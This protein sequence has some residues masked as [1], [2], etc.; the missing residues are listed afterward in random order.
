MGLGEKHDC[1]GL[2]GNGEPV[3]VVRSHFSRAGSRERGVLV[4]TRLSPLQCVPTP[5]LWDDATHF[6]VNPLW[7]SMSPR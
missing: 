7:E 2:L 3:A 6:L 5:S 1:G 4:H